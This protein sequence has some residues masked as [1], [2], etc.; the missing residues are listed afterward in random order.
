MQVAELTAD[1]VDVAGPDA[2]TSF[3]LRSLDG[4]PATTLARGLT[5]EPAVELAVQQGSDRTRAI[6]RP[7]ESL[8]PG[9]TYR[10]TLATPDGTVAG[11]WAFVVA[12]PPKVVGTLPYDRTTE[13]PVDTG[14]EIAFDR[15]GVADPTRWFSITPKVT[16]RFERHD[17]TWAFVP[18]ALAPST[19]YTVTLRAGV[20]LEGSDLALEEPVELRFRTAGPEKPHPVSIQPATVVAEVPT[21]EPPIVAIAVTSRGEVRPPKSVRVTLYRV[22]DVVAAAAI[23]SDLVERQQDW[24]FEEVETPRDTVDTSD[25]AV[26]ARLSVPLI[27]DTRDGYVGALRFQ[28]ALAQGWYLVDLPDDIA[29]GQQVLLQVTPVAAYTAMAR[30]RT[31]VWANRVGVGP[32]AGATVRLATGPVVGVT[33]TDGLMLAT[34]P[35][36]VLAT[37][38][39]KDPSGA[40]RPILVVEAPGLGAVVAPVGTS[41][42]SDT[43]SYQSSDWEPSAGV[44]T[45]R[46]A[47]TLATDRGTYR[48]TDSIAAWGMVHDAATGASPRT[49]RLELT[50]AGAEEYRWWESPALPRTP[51]AAADAATSRLGIFTATLGFADLPLGS[52]E[53]TLLVGEERLSSQWIEIGVVRKP[54]YTVDVSVDHRAVLAGDPVVVTGTAAFYDGTPVRGL[55]LRLT[56]S[57]ENGDGVTVSTGP[58]G[59]ASTL[60]HPSASGYA[61][62]S[63]SGAE[64]G[65]VGSAEVRVEVFPSA[66]E[67]GLDTADIVGEAVRVAGGVR[68]VDLDRVEAAIAADEPYEMVGPPAS[69][70][71]VRVEVSSTV[72]VARRTGTAYDFILKK[73]VPVYAYDERQLPTVTGTARTAADGGYALRLAL[74]REARGL[75]AQVQVQVTATDASGRQ[76]SAGSWG[77]R[78]EQAP[79][80]TLHTVWLDPGPDDDPRYGPEPCNWSWQSEEYGIGE[81]VRLTLRDSGGP[82]APGPSTRFLFLTA[83]DGIRDV[84]L[85]TSPRYRRV[86]DASEARG[87]TVLG[88]AFDGQRYRAAAGRFHAYVDPETRSIVVTVASDLAPGD[89]HAPGDDAWVRVATKDRSGRPLAADVVVRAIDE[90]LYDAGMA[91]DGGDLWYDYGY[92]SSDGVMGTFVSHVLPERI[93]QPGCGSTTGGG[94][95]PGGE[96]AI[97]TDFRDRVLFARVRTGSDGTARVPFHLSD[98]LTSWRVTASAVT[99][100]L[101][102]GS[103]SVNVPVGLPFFIEPVAADT[104]LAMDVPG[105]VLR[106][107][108]SALRTGDIVRYTVRAPALASAPVTV[109]AAAFT[110]GVAWVSRVGAAMPLGTHRIVVEAS[111]RTAGRLLRDAKEMTIEV[112]AARNGV[113]TTRTMAVEGEAR[114]PGGDD[115]LTTCTITDAGRASLVP[116]L[117]ELARGGPRAD[118]AAAAA[119][120]RDLLAEQLGQ[121]AWG[122]RS[123]DPAP[124]LVEGHGVSLLPYSSPDV[125]LTALVALG[126]PEAFPRTRTLAVYLGDTA[127]STG[128]PRDRRI[129][130]TV[131]LAALGF[132]VLADLRAAAAASDLTPTERAWLAV[133]LGEAGDLAGAAAMERALLAELGQRSGAWARVVVGSTAHTSIEATALLAIVAARIGD[134]L[135]PD[136]EAYVL[137]AEDTEAVHTLE[138]VAYATRALDRLPRTT[139]RVAYTIRGHRSEADLGPHRSVRLVLTPSQR[140]ETVVRT[141]DGAASMVCAWDAPA[142]GDDLPHDPALSIVR[143]VEPI[144]PIP[145]GSLVTVRLSV[146]MR[147]GA[148]SG[149][150][151]V[152]ETL[153]AGLAPTNDWAMERAA[154]GGDDE[155]VLDR[156]QRPWSIEGNRAEWG[157]WWGAGNEGRTLVFRVTARVV[158]PGGYAWEPAVVQLLSAPTVGAA[159]A[160]SGITV[161][162]P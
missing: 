61:A 100:D 78:R 17:R 22:P 10:F 82:I 12:A 23:A 40:P 6:V 79:K 43:S 154:D 14:I 125:E 110:A 57:A 143:S 101:R 2:R 135:A 115:A 120:A 49:V 145:P 1:D 36:E 142:A 93:S 126:A 104:V 51:V 141:L 161:L 62:A 58:D 91:W 81:T 128:E 76:D 122:S 150:Y 34:T 42:A 95:G 106:A 33:G 151:Q 72:W 156:E 74:P 138:G 88:V 55:P 98:D 107:Y 109:D 111:V 65:E 130:A 96:D 46:L 50:P 117:Q 137:D 4:T 157:F 121:E 47:S 160:A 64:L 108:G 48:R 63:T 53:L 21:G 114:P 92:G 144:G 37:I 20:P 77:E 44:A 94:G 66:Y 69:G 148:P 67:V 54:A 52:Y 162:A 97:R 32:I 123:F 84:T 29:A 86:L 8:A 118:Q 158:A 71:P 127:R 113:R 149:F 3:T 5:V 139:A 155:D 153:P 99:D 60:T 133:G 80:S 13:V 59:R 73:A 146:A 11:G 31:L 70:V 7:R 9:G 140:T 119:A 131:G 39:P 159:T 132:P 87:L 136:L 25:L 27:L 28:R 41:A 24:W 56:G 102:T 30:D 103:G 90:K 112:V 105:V 129:V 83:R 134:P 38:D 16:G 116:L 15:D 89:V 68:N 35:P 26:T 152:A 147:T 124:Y 85:S 18:D 19:V 45:S 75:R